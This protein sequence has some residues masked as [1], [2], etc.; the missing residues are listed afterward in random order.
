MNQMFYINNGDYLSKGF[1]FG[2]HNTWTHWNL[3]LV[4]KDT[5][6]PEPKTNLIELGG[7]SGTL[8]L[9]EALSGE[10]T[11]HNRTV[12]ASFWTNKG[13]YQERARLFGNITN[14]LH[15]RKMEIY[16]P[17]DTN[18][19]FYGRVKITYMKNTWAYSEFSIEAD[20]DPWRYET[21]EQKAVINVASEESIEW[22]LYNDS[23]MP[24][25]PDITVEGEV[26]F[27]CNGVTSEATTGKYKITTFKLSHGHNTILFS[28]N[29]TITLTY[30][31]GY[32]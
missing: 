27:T 30:R 1:Y 7:M 15:G 24:I 28:G 22:E 13:T 17:D 2:E 11:Y 16:E 9:S 6:P 3:I 25:C 5:T 14:A 18:H 26:S 12:K 10:V 4:S 8:D 32:L 21:V 19:Y 29:G 23:V 20:C 31:R